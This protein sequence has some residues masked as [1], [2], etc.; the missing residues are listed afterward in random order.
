MNGMCWPLAP[1]AR[2]TPLWPFRSASILVRARFRTFLWDELRTSTWRECAVA[3]WAFRSDPYDSGVAWGRALMIGR[4]EGR[5]RPRVLATRCAW[6]KNRFLAL[7]RNAA[8]RVEYFR[9]P[10]HRTVTVGERIEL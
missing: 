9:L 2:S 1:P 8:D 4:A 6:R 3:W 10:G 5:G 7:A